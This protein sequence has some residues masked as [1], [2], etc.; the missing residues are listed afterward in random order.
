MNPLGSLH[1]TFYLTVIACIFRLRKRRGRS[2]RYFMVLSIKHKSLHFSAG[3]CLAEPT[4]LE[5]AAFGVTGRRSNQIE[6]RLRKYRGYKYT[7][8]QDCSQV[9]NKIRFEFIKPIFPIAFSA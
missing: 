4:G 9:K 8:E 3:I 6:L 2:W 7:Q 1:S 5:P